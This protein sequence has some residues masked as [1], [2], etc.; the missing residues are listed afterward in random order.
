MLKRI[1]NKEILEGVR[2][3][4]LSAEDTHKLIKQ[5]NKIAKVKEGEI[6]YDNPKAVYMLFKKL[7]DADIKEI[8]NITEFEFMEAYHNPSP[9]M[10][11]ICFEI[12][13]FVSNAIIG[14]MRKNIASL[15][16]TEMLLLQSEAITKLNNITTSAKEIKKSEKPK[17]SKRINK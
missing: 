6:D 7:V 14:S 4:S 2:I 17:K 11:T 5:L 3:K 8:K 10:E 15:M 9:E 1:D 12:G 16:D 13:R